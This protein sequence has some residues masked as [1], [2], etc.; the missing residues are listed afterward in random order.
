MWVEMFEPKIVGKNSFLRY[1]FALHETT[2]TSL[3]QAS[4]DVSEIENGDFPVELLQT[5]LTAEIACV[6]RYTMI[7]ISRH[8]LR[9]Q[10]IGSEFQEQANDERKHMTM[11]AE[12]IRELGGKPNFDPAYSPL[13]VASPDG[14]VGDFVDYMR[15]DLAS[16]QCII[17]HY[18]DLIRYFSDRDPVTLN[19]L[20]SIVQDEENH[21][22]DIEDLL[23]SYRE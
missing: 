18:R 15:E 16:E 14:C 1:I 6:L 23:T 21:A 5:V 7:S 13:R 17:A 22:A 9:N 11:V 2:K 4:S 12:R 10:W 3:R 19:M 8:G 20:K